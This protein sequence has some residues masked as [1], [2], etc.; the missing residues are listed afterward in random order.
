MAL[1]EAAKEAIFLRRLLTS[2]KFDINKP[3]LIQTDSDSTLKNVKNNVNH[4]RTK[5]INCRHH[6]IREVHGTNEVDIQHIP[7]I[8]QVADILTRS[9]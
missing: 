4:L 3:L 7:A 2:L 8:E 6:Y 9:E 5:H 1:T